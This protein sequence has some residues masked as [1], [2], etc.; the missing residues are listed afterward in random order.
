[1]RDLTKTKLFGINIFDSYPIYILKDQ[2]RDIS[3]WR[4]L[5]IKRRLLK[6]LQK[7]VN[8]IWS[9]SIY[10]R[11]HLQLITLNVIWP[12]FFVNSKRVNTQKGVERFQ[13]F[14]TKKKIIFYNLLQIYIMTR[15]NILKENKDLQSF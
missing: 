15:L 14:S 12:N 3:L 6:Y 1:M 7:G 5:H 9:Y 11:A 10:A 2:S 13:Q 8:D 4:S